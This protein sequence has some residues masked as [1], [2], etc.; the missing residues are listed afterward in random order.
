MLLRQPS[1]EIRPKP[2]VRSSIRINEQLKES[3]PPSCLP[4]WVSWIG[5]GQDANFC[6]LA[7]NS[8]EVFKVI[9]VPGAEIKAIR[10]ISYDLCQFYS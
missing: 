1:N 3:Y 10:L 2:I 9:D 8:T 5:F 4:F 7:P 6:Q